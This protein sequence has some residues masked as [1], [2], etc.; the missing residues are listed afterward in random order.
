MLIRAKIA[1]R[2]VPGLVN[3]VPPRAYYF[4]LALT[5]AFTQPEAHLLA[6]PCRLCYVIALC[7]ILHFSLR[8]R[9]M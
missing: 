1:Q 7:D 6:D 2:Q 4:C 9:E 3:L 8:A 5:A